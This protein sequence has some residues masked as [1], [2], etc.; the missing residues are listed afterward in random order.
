MKRIL[1]LVLALVL[2]LGS[3]PMAF[4]AK[5]GGE[6]LRDAGFISG[7]EKGN[8]NE[9]DP[10]TRAQL[11]V[12]MAQLN[13]VFDEAKSYNLAGS[14]SDVD[15]NSDWF[16]PYVAYAEMAEWTAGY[17]DG[18][19]RPEGVVTTKELATLIYK[20]LEYPMNEFDFNRSVLDVA[21]IGVSVI[22]DDVNAMKRGEA[23]DALWETVN[24]EMYNSDVT[25]GVHLGKL[26]AEEEEEEVEVTPDFGDASVDSAVALGNSVVEVT[27]KDD[28]DANAASN[29]NNYK[30]KEKSGNKTIN[31]KQAVV[32]DSDRVLLTTDALTVNKAYTLTVNGESANFVGI[33]ASTT[34][35]KVVKVAAVDTNL[36]EIAYDRVVDHSTA[37]DV[38]NYSLDKGAYAVDATLEA[39]GKMVVLET[40]G[41]DSRTTYKVTIDGVESV[42]G[43]E[44]VKVTKSFTGRPDTTPPTISKIEP[45][46]NTMIYVY[47][48]DEHGV[49]KEMIENRSNWSIN[50]DVDIFDIT[51]EKSSDSKY[52]DYAVVGTSGQRTGTKYTLTISNLTDG[53]TAQNVAT[54]DLS[55]TF[56]AKREDTGAPVLSS[57]VEVLAN[58][59][60]VISFSDESALDEGSLFD[61]SNYEIDGDVDVYSVEWLE[62]DADRYTPEG[63]KV[64]VTTSEQTY[65]KSL[66]MTVSGIADEFGNTMT[67]DAYVRWTSQP[68]RNSAP[69][70]KSVKVTDATTVELTFSHA[71]D[72]TTA[73]D[74][75][76]YS[77][78]DLG[79]PSKAVVKSGT[80]DVVVLT[81]PEGTPGKTYTITI[82]GVE[83]NSGNVVSNKT[84]KYTAIA[85]EVD[86]SAFEVSSAYIVNE[87]E[88]RVTFNK[89][90]NMRSGTQM[91]LTKTSTGSNTVDA[92]ATFVAKVDEE[93]VFN[94]V[95]PSKFNSDTDVYNILDI[96]YSG[97]TIRDLYGNTLD[98][99][100]LQYIELFANTIEGDI[101]TVE[102]VEHLN[103][104]KIAVYFSQPMISSTSNISYSTS[105]V[106]FNKLT[107]DPDN[108]SIVYLE[109][110]GNITA[111]TNLKVN[112]SKISTLTNVSGKTAESRDVEVYTYTFDSKPYVTT[113]EATYNNEIAVHFDQDMMAAGTYR[114]YDYDGKLRA[115]AN[116]TRIE[117]DTV[118]ASWSGFKMEEGEYYTVE[119]AGARAF[120]NKTVDTERFDFDGVGTE[121]VA[122]IT[123]VQVVGPHS[124]VVYSTDDITDV[125]S[126]SPGVEIS[127]VDMDDPTAVVVYTNQVLRD[128]TQYTVS[129]DM[130]GGFNNVT[131][132][133]YGTSY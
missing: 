83:D 72:K 29:T 24:T 28:M 103:A 78:A 85:G 119:V 66:K 125:N 87:S 36:V 16:A 89:D 41:V 107:I 88:I 52:Y 64:V 95:T 104:K 96:K 38:D 76:N 32:A 131:F 102:Y 100:G 49:D 2:V 9:S 20:A 120:N 46:T 129:V 19:F 74:S 4:A 93:Y 5:T 112:M 40:E 26:E 15:Y 126:V 101:P 6:E 121:R 12:L 127:N 45:K 23:F 33:K 99:D 109:T 124:F 92:T 110:N 128:D 118:Y 37:T 56:Y 130:V 25:L 98:K 1:S 34:K 11:M 58:D 22:A 84:A 115:T 3:L 27:F 81:V 65:P 10:L 18:T 63:R 31:V 86:D 114:I 13:G 132:S 61:T 55:K 47:F 62:D 70:V 44:M 94:L 97:S 39:G 57:T 42:D 79:V 116:E 113:V 77:I 51:A 82:N 53:S 105:G 59:K 123:G 111:N 35:P 7:D 54:K 108:S 21:R 48:N 69:Y 117:G 133:F 8:L 75:T 43:Y 90:Y 80:T 122:Y 60:I 73:E 17:P 30:I 50:N 67:R 71:V 68:V 14:F 106:V 91:T